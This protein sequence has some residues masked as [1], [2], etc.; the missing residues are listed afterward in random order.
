MY[1]G[2]KAMIEEEK[3][4][5]KAGG[6]AGAAGHAQTHAQP[7]ADTHVDTHAVAETKCG[8]H[9]KK[10][11]DIVGFPKFPADTKS[12]LFKH[13]TPELYNKYKDVKDKHG[14]SFKSAILSG[15]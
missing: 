8:P 6:G 12:L 14:F 7:H 4:L 13:L 2:V 9:L 5:Q 1:D 10:A 15:C 3:K 11:E